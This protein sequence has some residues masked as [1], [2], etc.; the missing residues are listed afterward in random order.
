MHDPRRREF[1]S[2]SYPVVFPRLSTVEFEQLPACDGIGVLCCR[3]NDAE[4]AEDHEVECVEYVKYIAF[5]KEH[6]PR[7]KEMTVAEEGKY[8]KNNQWFMTNEVLCIML[9]VTTGS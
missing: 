1:P 4:F 3:K 2:V 5:G 9:L 7:L 8:E 6:L